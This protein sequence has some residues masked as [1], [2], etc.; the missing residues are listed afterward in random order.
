MTNT[1][2]IDQQLVVDLNS[3][4]VPGGLPNSP[5]FY[6]R[7]IRSKGVAVGAVYHQDGLE[8]AEQTISEEEALAMAH[9]FKASPVLYQALTYA[10][11]FMKPEEVN[12]QYIDDV[13]AYARGAKDEP[14]S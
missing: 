12:V 11:R 10:R 1:V 9:L 4:M 5:K 2:N 6:E 8:R 3:T 14:P 13:L 7:I